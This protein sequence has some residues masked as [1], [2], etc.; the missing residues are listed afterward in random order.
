MHFFK[1]HFQVNVDAKDKKE[2]DE[3][4]LDDELDEIAPGVIR[5]FIPSTI[6]FFNACTHD[7]RSWPGKGYA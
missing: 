7:F 6:F 1:D 4:G 3:S 5:E 2:A